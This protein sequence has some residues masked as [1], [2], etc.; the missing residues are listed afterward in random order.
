VKIS[1]RIFSLLFAPGQG[2]SVFRDARSLS[3]CVFEREWWRSFGKFW[4]IVSA[5]AALR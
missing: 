5:V 3:G 2:T 1:R 4:P